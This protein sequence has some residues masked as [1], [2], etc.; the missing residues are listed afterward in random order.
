MIETTQPPVVL[1]AEGISKVYPGTVALKDV[2]FDVY[3]HAVN[4]LI[5]EN[6]AG[7]STLMKIVA[8][9]EQPSAGR[10]V[11]NGEPVR[12]DSVRDAASK[13]IGIVF[14]E[15]NLCPN[16]TVTENIFLGRDL[17]RAGIHIDRV[18][19][20]AKAVE[21]LAHL[22]HD[23]D[24]DTL[25]GELRIGEQQVVEI[26]KSLAENAEVLILDEPTSALSAAEVEVLFKVIGE[27]KRSGVAI[28]YISH[29]LDELMR[30]GDYFTV[31][32]DGHLQAAAR[33]EQVTIPWI[34]SAMLGKSEIVVQRKRLG[35]V[36][37]VALSVSGITLARRG[38]GYAVDHVSADFRAG[39]ITAIY[40]LLGAGRSELLECL[41]GLRP[42]SKGSVILGGHELSARS[43]TG[44]M[45]LGLLLVPEDRQRDG[46][47]QNLSV[48][49][50]LGLASLGRFTRFFSISRRLEAPL[51]GEIIAGLQIKTA[52]ADSPITSLSGGNQQKVVIGKSLLTAPK[53]LLLDEPS[54]GID[55][56]A[57]AEVFNAMRDLAEQGMAVIFTTSDLKETHAVADRV[58]VMAYGR[59]TADVSGKE[60]SDENLVRASTL[61]PSYLRPQDIGRVH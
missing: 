44:R 48:G 4:V 42:E 27:L 15:L 47:V 58:L 41:Y 38:G 57:K 26:A 9:V 55:I 24:P 59:L 19:Q 6:G 5:G 39:E 51:L 17:T 10:L 61:S 8:G 34:I 29:R 37:D 35:A 52:S 12:F 7:K 28:I 32:R 14:Q 56:G 20:R 3:S 25:V 31:L 45:K 43:V 50:N 49:G 11:M 2:D 54:R 23:I 22:E 30:I 53:V 1:H 46:L 33:R 16:L 13:G 21:L 40:G 18:A 36:G 60:V